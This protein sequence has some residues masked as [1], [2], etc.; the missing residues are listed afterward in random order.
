MVLLCFLVLR[1]RHSVF[2]AAI[3]GIGAAGLYERIRNDCDGYP[4]LSL[5]LVGLAA[6][7]LHLG[8]GLRAVAV[9]GRFAPE[10]TRRALGA[11]AV[12]VAV[13]AFFF[14]TD[15]LAAYA[16]G[17]PLFSVGR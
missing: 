17:A 3:E 9:R 5:Y 2:F 7:G 14:L 12:V 11:G 16:I 8:Q 6:L 4:F 10:P 15:A 13:L 1:A